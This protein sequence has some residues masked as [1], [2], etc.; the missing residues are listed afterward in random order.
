MNEQ[1]Y[2]EQW[3]KRSF[4]AMG[5]QMA[6]WLDLENADKAEALLQEAEDMFHQAEARLSRFDPTSELSQLNARSG[7][8]TLVSDMMWAVVAQALFMAHETNGLFDPTQLT[9]LEAVGYTHSF[10]QMTAAYE[11]IGRETAVRQQD[12]WQMVQLNPEARA[13]W[14]P[15]GIKLDLGGIAKGF[16]AQQVVDFLSE[17]GPCLVDASGDLTAGVAPAG[18]PGWPVAVAAPYHD[19]DEERADLFSLW[20]VEGTMATSGIDY[21][22]WQYNG[23]SAHHVIDPRTCLPAE[24]DLLT[25]TVLAK[26][27]VRAEAWATAAL[28]AGTAVAQQRLTDHN[29]AAALVDQQC[30][31]AFTPALSPFLGITA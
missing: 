17:W 6:V 31:L 2:S 3:H 27:A 11:A 25:V 30:G 23:R 21:R 5:C 16:T 20:L 14:L 8:W 28:V 26:T 13:I 9:A 12:Q 4:Q 19:P 15:P 29:L 10:E 1:P 22:R 24:T 18:Q 7:T